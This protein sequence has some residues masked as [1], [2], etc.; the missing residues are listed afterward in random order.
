[1]SLQIVYLSDLI[2]QFTIL[3]NR[4]PAT[5]QAECCA[6][7]LGYVPNNATLESITDQLETLLADEHW[8]HLNRLIDEI[9]A[10]TNLGKWVYCHSLHTVICVSLL[11]SDSHVFSQIAETEK[12]A[13]ITQNKLLQESYILND[14]YTRYNKNLG[15]FERLNFKF[16]L[17]KFSC[18]VKSSKQFTELEELQEVHEMWSSIQDYIR[19]IVSERAILATK[20]QFKF[21]MT[22]FN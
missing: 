16:Q 20:D 3:W 10:F 14:F 13:N 17:Y 8:Y 2:D 9:T 18:L 12:Q 15:F 19:T 4:M 7:V 11:T 22:D 21:H 1:M 6:R 5:K